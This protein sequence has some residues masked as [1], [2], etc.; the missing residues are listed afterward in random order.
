VAGFCFSAGEGQEMT[1]IQYAF[2]QTL[3]KSTTL[4]VAMES[5]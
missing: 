4:A 5:F 2:R 3:N 1:D